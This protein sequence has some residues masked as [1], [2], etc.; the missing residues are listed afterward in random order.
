MLHSKIRYV[1]NENCLSIFDYQLYVFINT[2]CV[3]DIYIYIYNVN[4][5][6]FPIYQKQEF[7]NIYIA[8]IEIY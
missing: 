1:L 5:S 2:I 4:R 8:E 3:Y 6:T 7:K